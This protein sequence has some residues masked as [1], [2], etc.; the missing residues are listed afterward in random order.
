[1]K[2]KILTGMLLVAFLCFFVPQ[3]DY[4]QTSIVGPTGPSSATVPSVLGFSLASVVQLNADAGETNPFTQGV[5]QTSPNFDFG[6]LRNV[7]DNAGNFLYMR[8]QFYYYVL[9]IATTSG[10]RYE[11]TESGTQLTSGGGATIANESVLLIPDYQWLD[12]LGGVA[13]GGPPSGAFVGP[14]ATACATNSV[15]YQSD[16]AGVAKLVRAIV[17]IG[18]PQAGASFPFNFS[19]GFNGS[20]GQGTQQQFTLWKPI[21]PS[22]PTGT[23]TGTVT[24]TLVL[25]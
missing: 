17:T 12:Q 15:V 21:T 1:M 18:G 22:Q 10:R 14:P 19:Q 23:Y 3:S 16:T 25:D 9:M 5:T 2:Q 4:A 24:F 20:T 13:Q 7:T 6:T 11:I 8:G